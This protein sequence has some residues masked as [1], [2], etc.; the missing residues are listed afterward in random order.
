VAIIGGFATSLWCHQAHTLSLP[1]TSRYLSG[2]MHA[3]RII[4]ISHSVS[5]S[6]RLSV[7]IPLTYANTDTTLTHSHAHK[8]LILSLALFLAQGKR[9]TIRNIRT[10][11]QPN[12]THKVIHT[13]FQTHVEVHI[14]KHLQLETVSHTH[15]DTQTMILPHIN[16]TSTSTCTQPHVRTNT[17][18]HICTPLKS[19]RAA[20]ASQKEAR[21]RLHRLSAPEH[22]TSNN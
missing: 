6:I 1:L 13:L 15:T 9:Y 3:Y 5:V 4:L 14:Q 7:L 16:T 12:R 11:T 10:Q 19:Y 21:H 18:I 17:H 20:H 22:N 8:P 2:W